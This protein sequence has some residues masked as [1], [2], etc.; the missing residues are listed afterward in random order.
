LI[1]SAVVANAATF[2][3]TDDGGIHRKA[4][5]LGLTDRVL[6]VEDALAFLASLLGLIPEPPPLVVRMKAYEL[7]VA[8]PIFDSFRADYPGFDDWFGR[9]QL[10]HRSAWVIRERNALAAVCI[11]K[12]DDDE[13]HLGGRMSGTV[14]RGCGGDTVTRP[15]FRQLSFGRTSKAP[16]KGPRSRYAGRFHSSDPST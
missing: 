7:S 5:R 4:V 15:G 14:P 11:I 9:C 3:V 16:N 2:L 12:E 6:T 8:D 13:L 10:E 1:L